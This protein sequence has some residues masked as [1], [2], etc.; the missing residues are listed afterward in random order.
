MNNNTLNTLLHDYV[1]GKLSAE[2]VE[3]VKKHLH[4]NPELNKD[5]EDI[6]SYYNNLK[7]LEPVK[8]PD[9]FLDKV[10]ERINGN[11]PLIKKIFSAQWLKAEFMGLAF[12]VLLVVIIINPFK[13]TDA[14]TITYDEVPRPNI[15]NTAIEEK[16]IEIEEEKKQSIPKKKAKPTKPNNNI[17]KIKNRAKARKKVDLKVLDT[18]DA[19]LIKMKSEPKASSPK[20]NM[21]YEESHEVLDDKTIL[22]QLQSLEKTEKMLSVE[23]MPST[24]PIQ[25]NKV[26]KAESNYNSEQAKEIMNFKVD[27]DSEPPAKE[28]VKRKAKRSA[29]KREKDSNKIGS[30]LAPREKKA[31]ELKE[32]LEELEREKQI[33]AKSYK[34]KAYNEQYDTIEEV[35]KVDDISKDDITYMIR[36]NLNTFKNTVLVIDRKDK[37]FMIT[38]QLKDFERF[39]SWLSVK[40]KDDFK[41]LDDS[42]QKDKITFK[43][44]F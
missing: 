13:Y 39:K 9:D 16:V 5:I 17:S 28:K 36:R 12:S 43:L 29:Q 31:R 41:I 4:N 19:D 27:E 6:K 23:Q 21:I 32:K 14:P 33:E 42:I 1:Q 35:E 22:K 20:V 3:L 24:A 10:H 38:M 40:F 30:Y 8:A 18:I 26:Q 34:S 37:V 44:E 11:V 15:S 2:E 7:L 25:L